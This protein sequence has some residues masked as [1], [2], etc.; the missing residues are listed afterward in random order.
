MPAVA[1]DTSAIVEWMIDGPQVVARVSLDVERSIVV[2][3]VAILAIDACELWGKGRARA[4]L[5]FGNCFSYA[6]A[7][8][9]NL[10][11]PYVG[12]DFSQTGLLEA[13]SSNMS[14][15]VRMPSL[16]RSSWVIVKWSA[17]ATATSGPG[18]CWADLLS[19]SVRLSATKGGSSAVP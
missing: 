14:C 17:P 9:R 2:I 1:V 7:S 19:C 4:N 10:P 11:L 3:S 12:D 18:R 5:H 13:Q 6:L 16:S 8:G 15:R